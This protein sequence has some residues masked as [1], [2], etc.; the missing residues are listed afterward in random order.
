MKLRIAENI[1]FEFM[2]ELANTE[3]YDK[4]VVEIKGGTKTTEKANKLLSRIYDHLNSK[5]LKEDDPA[6]YLQGYVDQLNELKYDIEK[7]IDEL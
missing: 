6:I 7:K 2:E 3:L 1:F 5:P 4:Y